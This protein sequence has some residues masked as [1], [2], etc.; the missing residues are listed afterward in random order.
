[1]SKLDP[2]LEVMLRE[3]Q[4][5]LS[6]AADEAAGAEEEVAPELV[7]V[8]MKFTG[9]IDELTALGFEPE[10]V[11]QNLATGRISLE[12]LPALAE[13]PNLVKLEI[14]RPLHPELNVSGPSIGIPSLHSGSPARKG[15]GVI[16]GMIDSGIDYRHGSF[17]KADDTSRIL[18]LWDMLPPSGAS[19]SPPSGYSNGIE[20][21]QTQINNALTNS[22]PLSVV[23]S[24]DTNGHGTHTAGIA[25]GNGRPEGNCHGG[26]TFVGMAPEADLIVVKLAGAAELGESR[27]LINAVDYIFQKAD[28]ASK[29]AVINISLGDNLGAH[30][31]TSLVEQF[32]DLFLL[33]DGRAIV[34]SAGNEGNDD[35]HAKGTLTA[36]GS[37]GTNV[38]FRVPASLS[39]EVV[40]D[41]WYE[42]PDRFD[43]SITPPTGSGA[44]PVSPGNLITN[45][46]LGNGNTVTINSQLTDPDN[47]DNRIQIEIRKGTQTNI[48]AGTWTINLAASTLS[49]G[50]YHVWI[51]R[52]TRTRFLSPSIETTISVPGTAREVIT[53]GSYA[54]RGVTSG[55]LSDFSSQGPAR[56]GV[57]K[58]EIVAPGDGIMSAKS[59]SLPSEPACIDLCADRYKPLPGTSM[60]APHVA[61]VIALMLEKDPDLSIDD[62]RTH[63][64]SNTTTNP[65]MGTLPNNQWG[66]GIVNAPGAVNAVP[67]SSDVGGP[68]PD[69]SPVTEDP[70][71]G[72]A[73]LPAPGGLI[74]SQS[75][76]PIEPSGMAG[77]MSALL[78]L[79]QGQTYV[80]LVRKHVQEVRTLINT[81]RRVATVWLRRNGPEIMRSVLYASYDPD[82]P[83][84]EQVND[85]PVVQSLRE[86]FAI[87]QRYGSEALRADIDRHGPALL[88]LQGM[89][90]N[91]ILA[92]LR[93]SGAQAS[94]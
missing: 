58:P 20:Y 66:N 51:E 12:D 26:G 57:R 16:V 82:R 10:T 7:S 18:F 86:I 31:G 27:N 55:D 79:P 32:M 47:N 46:A 44:G 28:A 60:A 77:G 43:I 94:D 23:P 42:G 11:L 41:L 34:K 68:L 65:G 29:P 74:L 4:Q 15:S 53:V 85:K 52:D 14:S 73:P 35:R 76:P 81:N 49:D 9:D 61:G 30:D 89:S 62:I 67:V 13:H 90:F 45:S 78:D 25:A 21:T 87:L 93:A 56:D 1:M 72:D 64:F 24:E 91:Q 70:G 6:L 22:N 39:H 71:M 80:N 3:R 59:G 17:R 69:D 54:D 40:M 36:T 2:K 19:G 83:L 33:T 63:L 8:L 84:P 88:Q 5:R 75:Q 48:A 38:L 37:P 50:N 92:S